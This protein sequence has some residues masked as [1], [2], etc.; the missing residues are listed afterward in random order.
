MMLPDEIRHLL[1]AP[2]VHAAFQRDVI[3][4]AVVFDQF[5]RAETLMTLLTVHQRI[6]ESSQMAGRHPGL[7]VHQNRAVHAHIVGRLL[8]KFLPPG[9][10]Y[11]I[12]QLHTQI[13]IIPGIGKASVNLGTGIYK[14][15]GLGQSHNL[16]H[17]LFHCLFLLNFLT[18]NFIIPF[19]NPF[20][21]REPA[22][23]PDFSR[24]N[25]IRSRSSGSE[26]PDF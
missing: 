2:A 17:R 10:F 9:F 1:L 26:F 15:S 4:L 23:F 14:S 18:S 6:G 11:V 24:K 19:N 13:S 5:V 12:F 21:N 20:V 7:R 8:D 25:P 16:F 3:R 22:V